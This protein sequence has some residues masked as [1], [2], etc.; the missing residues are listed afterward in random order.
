MKTQRLRFRY[1]V[2]AE[3]SSL[4]QRELVR[5]WEDAAVA[6]GLPLAYSEGKRPAAQISLAAPL[7][8]NVTSDGERVDIFFGERVDPGE[9][10]ASLAEKLPC[11]VQAAGVEEI[12]VAAPSL[13]SQLRWAEYEVELAANG[14]GAEGLREAITRL[15]A[16][17]E[18]PSEY[19]RETK[20]RQYDLRP[21]ILDLRLEGETGECLLLRMRLRAEPE[22]TG[23]AD[24]VVLALGWPEAKRV[25]RRELRVEEGQAVVMAYRRLGEPDED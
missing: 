18:L 1:R 15:L 22:M 19:R 20:V 6:V 17:D 2:T 12:G 13:Q 3:A 4:S 23:R 10:L 9:A 7:P 24:Q 11:G 25:H 21:L 5:A 14:R 16:A 8:L